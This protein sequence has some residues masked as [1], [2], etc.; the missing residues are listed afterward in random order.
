MRRAFDHSG[1]SNRLFVVS[2]GRE[3]LDYLQGTGPYADRQ[4]YPLPGL[5]LMDLK[6]PTMNGFEVLEWL[7]SRPDF[8]TLPVVILS[9]SGLSGDVERAEK[10]GVDDYRVKSS[11]LKHLTQMLYELQTRWLNGHRKGLPDTNVAS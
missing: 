10:L 9:G 2:N 6:M 8:K 4:S 7:Q 5:L 11:N 3:V 1:L